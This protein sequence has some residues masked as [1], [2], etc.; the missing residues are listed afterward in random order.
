MFLT[1]PGNNEDAL[2]FRNMLCDPLCV[3]SFGKLLL[4]CNWG[5][6]LW[7]CLFSRDNSSIFILHQLKCLLQH[8]IAITHWCVHTTLLCLQVHQLSVARAWYVNQS[9]WQNLKV[10]HSDW[11]AS[12]SLLQRSVATWE[13]AVLLWFSVPAAGSHG[14]SLSIPTVCC[15]QSPL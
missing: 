14:F 13:N 3:A 6:L 9:Q 10:L 5:D 4:N 2:P 8:M 7:W 15:F 11:M 1:V 12:L